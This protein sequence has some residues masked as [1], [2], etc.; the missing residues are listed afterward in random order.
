MRITSAPVTL[1]GNHTSQ[2]LQKGGILREQHLI[3]SFV[4]GTNL[5][6]PVHLFSSQ[7]VLAHDSGTRLAPT[8]HEK[9][10]N[11]RDCPLL[12]TQRHAVEPGPEVVNP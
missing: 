10:Q 9:T 3:A 1:T 5:V 4:S 7:H 2:V 8:F 12:V 11:T 6:N